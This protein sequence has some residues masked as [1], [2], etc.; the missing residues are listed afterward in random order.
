MWIE[1]G[2]ANSSR[3]LGDFFGRLFSGCVG[4]GG[5]CRSSAVVHRLPLGVATL[6][7]G[8]GGVAPVGSLGS[9]LG[10]GRTLRSATVEHQLGVLVL[11]QHSLQG[12]IVFG[13][14]VHCARD[15]TLRERVSATCVDEHA[16]TLEG[17][18]GLI[19]AVDLELGVCSRAFGFSGCAFVASGVG[20]RGRTT[21]EYQGEREQSSKSQLLHES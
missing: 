6:V 19:P 12:V 4:F 3:L 5:G 20:T 14:C 10:A 17:S 11:G 13:G 8:D 15:V 9:G 2:P 18:L 7:L 1:R 16:T 21:G